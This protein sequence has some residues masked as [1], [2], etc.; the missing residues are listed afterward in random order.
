MNAGWSSWGSTQEVSGP[1]RRF[2]APAAENRATEAMAWLEADEWAAL[3]GALAQLAGL[4]LATDRQRLLGEMALLCRR[5]VPAAAWA[6]M[7]V[8]SP[9]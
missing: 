6:S 2:D 5:V 4:P 3:A 7:I 8:G 1:P 9:L